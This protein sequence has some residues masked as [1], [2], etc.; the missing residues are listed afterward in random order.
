M[1]NAIVE[2]S[3]YVLCWVTM[4]EGIRLYMSQFWYKLWEPNWRKSWLEY[5]YA[6]QII[7]SR[8]E[9]KYI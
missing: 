2:T 4:Y 9:C 7:P 1:Y 5:T 3:I 6:E 8:K